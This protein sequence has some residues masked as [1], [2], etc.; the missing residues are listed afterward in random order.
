MGLRRRQVGTFQ[1]LETYVSASLT[2]GLIFPLILCHLSH[3]LVFLLTYVGVE[4]KS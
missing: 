2:Y 4:E 1:I 3:Y